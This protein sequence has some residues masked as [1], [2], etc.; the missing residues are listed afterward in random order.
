M[1][2]I[3]ERRVTPEEALSLPQ[4][5]VSRGGVVYSRI[6]DPR[7]RIPRLAD[8]YRAPQPRPDRGGRE[9]SVTFVIKAGGARTL[10]DL[11]E[12]L[13][14]RGWISETSKVES[15]DEK[16]ADAWLVATREEPDA[17]T[18]DSLETLDEEMEQIAARLSIVYD[19]HGFA[20]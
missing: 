4:D 9:I 19:G 18:S 7:W 20:L 14:S 13:A 5:D 6:A 10:A 15:E 16:S 12:E 3:G 8:A 2:I 11:E 17:L 1:S